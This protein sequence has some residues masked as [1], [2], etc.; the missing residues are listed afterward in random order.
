MLVETSGMRRYFTVREIA[1]LQALPVDSHIEGSWAH[2][3][4]QTENAVPAVTIAEIIDTSV[5]RTLTKHP[6]LDFSAIKT[7]RSHLHLG[8]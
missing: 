7:S 5:A 6:H 3:I 4:C 2:A 1:R 8:A